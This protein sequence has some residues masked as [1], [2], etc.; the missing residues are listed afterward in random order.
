MTH[1]NR[2]ALLLRN[3]AAYGG[4]RIYGA[5][6]IEEALSG[7]MDRLLE[8]RRIGFGFGSLACGADILWAE[9][10]IRRNAEL[11]LFIPGTDEQFVA[12]S[13]EPG[14]P[15]WLQRFRTQ[16]D[17]ATSVTRVPRASGPWENSF[18]SISDT[19]F[20]AAIGTAKQRQAEVVLVE[21]WDGSDDDG[22][23]AGTAADI[24]AW[25]RHGLPVYLVASRG[26]RVQAPD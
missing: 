6:D 14:G 10:L 4:H 20:A 1:D 25:R 9:A 8:E 22:R 17:A 26:T 23:S 11:H 15:G 2:S 19:A 13:V 7:E 18:R 16:L 5:I 24:D 12:E 21:V 3:V